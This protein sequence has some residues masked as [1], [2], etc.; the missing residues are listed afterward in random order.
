MKRVVLSRV[1][2]SLFALALSACAS[3]SAP[4][5]GASLE[6][7]ADI[8]ASVSAIESLLSARHADDLPTET[9]LSGHDQPAAALR[10]IATHHRRMVVR[11]RALAS[12]RHYRDDETRTLLIGTL[13]DASAHP[14]LRAAAARGTASL[15]LDADLR[16]AL[17]AAG[18]TDDPRIAGA[19]QARL[20]T[21]PSIEA[22]ANSGALRE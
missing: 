12:L 13:S 5:V 9:T 20:G 3:Q 6:E 16:A 15:S 8:P 17:E 10:H 18:R 1:L 11:G 4:P 21:V 7:P 19:V 14:T 2:A 22:P